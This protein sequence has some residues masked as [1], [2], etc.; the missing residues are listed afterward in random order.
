MIFNKKPNVANLRV[1]G[2]RAYVHVPE[3]LRK[4]LESK[5]KPGWLVGYG[6]ETK[7]WII[8]EPI[9]RKFIMSRDVIFNEDL[10][11]NDFNEETKE[12]H[13]CLFNPFFYRWKYL[14]W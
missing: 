1:I 13:I 8:W 9:S 2:C 3:Q 11:I 14:D 6:K 5:A 10:L 12:K 7:G 4:K